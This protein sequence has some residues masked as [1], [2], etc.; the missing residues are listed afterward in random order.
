[1]ILEICLIDNC[2]YSSNERSFPIVAK[3]YTGESVEIAD[4]IDLWTIRLSK[5]N[6]DILAMYRRCILGLGPRDTFIIDKNKPHYILYDLYQGS[7]D[8]EILPGE[9]EA[10][11]KLRIYKPC[12]EDSFKEEY[13]EARRTI[14]IK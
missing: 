14:I 3:L 10:Y 8:E 1:M 9:Y 13:I 11:I 7:E 12:E 4:K 2:T 6:E 5:N